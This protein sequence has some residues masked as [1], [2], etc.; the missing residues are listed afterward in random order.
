MKASVATITLWRMAALCVAV[1]SSK[2]EPDI[3]VK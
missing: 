1:S 3:K 2:D